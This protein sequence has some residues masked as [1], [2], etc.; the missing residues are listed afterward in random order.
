MKILAI[1]KYEIKSQYTHVAFKDAD[2]WVGTNVL[3]LGYMR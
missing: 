3:T 2:E 1:N